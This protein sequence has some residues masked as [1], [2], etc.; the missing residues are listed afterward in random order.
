MIE[1][2]IKGEYLFCF[3]NICL[4]YASVSVYGYVHANTGA[5]GGYRPDI[6]CGCELPGLSAGE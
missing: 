2:P 6:T 3:Q 5:H 4:L 1:Y